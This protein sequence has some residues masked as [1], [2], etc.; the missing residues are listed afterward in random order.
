MEAVVDDQLPSLFQHQPAS[1]FG[2]LLEPDGLASRSDN[3]H[4]QE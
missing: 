2:C 3:R 1:V 4:G